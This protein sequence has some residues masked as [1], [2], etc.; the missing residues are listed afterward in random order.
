MNCPYKI[1][2][3]WGLC[4]PTNTN[5]KS[6]RQ[7]WLPRTLTF[8]LYIAPNT[9]LQANSRATTVTAISFL[10]NLPVNSVIST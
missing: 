8:I 10:R 2:L 9:N 3:T 4:P 5:K 7:R 6:P 1:Y